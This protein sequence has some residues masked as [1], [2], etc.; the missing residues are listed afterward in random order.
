MR[1][2]MPNFEVGCTGMSRTEHHMTFTSLTTG[3]L[4]NRF[5]IPLGTIISRHI[6][7]LPAYAGNILQN[8][9][10]VSFVF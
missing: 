4:A 9:L 6:K 10:K 5:G 1:K 3:V 7:L 2:Y 8:I